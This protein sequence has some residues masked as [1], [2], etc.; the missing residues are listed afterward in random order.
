MYSVYDVT[1][2][3]N[4]VEAQLAAAVVDMEASDGLVGNVLVTVVHIVG[5]VVQPGRDGRGIG[6]HVDLVEHVER[7]FL[8]A[9]V[10]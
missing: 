9:V 8:R 6:F 5:H 2:L 7:V 3:T 10:R 4:T 1:Q